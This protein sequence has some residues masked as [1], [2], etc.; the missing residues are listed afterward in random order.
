MK[1]KLCIFLSIFISMST[2]GQVIPKGTLFIGGDFNI[3]Y[4]KR[5]IAG[6]STTSNVWIVGITPSITKFKK[7][8]A[9]VTYSLGYNITTTGISSGSNNSFFRYSTHNVSAG[10]YF[11]NYKMITEKLGVSLQYGV[12]LGYTFRTDSQGKESLNNRKGV[13]LSFNTGPGII[14]LL[15]KKI[16]IEGITSL[17]SFNTGYSW[18]RQSNTFNIDAS[19]RVSPNLG[20]G[21]RY[22][23][24]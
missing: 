3:N 10:M 16:A 13:D 12:G 2:F 4:T 1:K 15:N 20:I 9:S 21:I 8:N 5:K 17:F 22:L 11:R 14:Y 6:S 7:D 23:L 18:L 19:V 24:K